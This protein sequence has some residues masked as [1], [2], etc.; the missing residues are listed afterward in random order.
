M[1]EEERGGK[2][3]EISKQRMKVM[4][5]RGVEWGGGKSRVKGKW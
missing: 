1:N 2:E 4:M 5:R 3:S